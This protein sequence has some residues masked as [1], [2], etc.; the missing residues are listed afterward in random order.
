MHVSIVLDGTNYTLGP[1]IGVRSESRV[2]LSNACS[3]S[4]TATCSLLTTMHFP[5]VKRL[6]VTYMWHD[7]VLVLDGGFGQL[8]FLDAV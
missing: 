8:R 6:G 3:D 2:P 1:A 5:L 7:V 4:V